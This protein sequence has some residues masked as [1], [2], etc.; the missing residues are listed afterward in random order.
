MQHAIAPLKPGDGIVFDAADW[1]SPEAREE[2]GRI[3]QVTPA[4]SGQLELQF[5]NGAIDFARVRAGDLVWRTHDP[6]LDK[7]VR[8]YTDAPA[9]VHK[10]PVRV[11]VTA[12]EG[13]PLVLE[14]SLLR[15]PDNSPDISVIVRAEEPL[16]QAANRELDAESLRAQLDRL[17]NTAYVLRELEVDVRG[18]PFVPSSLLNQLRR[19]AVDL[20]AEQQAQVR[21]VVVRDAHTVLA[22][23]IERRRDEP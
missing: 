2:G 19:Q 7:V 1:R 23:A 9:P 6:A 21:P 8:T 22:G 17:G 15:R 16:V 14:W 18:R 4:R 12:Y 20:L 3:Y 13:E 5:G 10:Q 11:R